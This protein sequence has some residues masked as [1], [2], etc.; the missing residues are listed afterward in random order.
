MIRYSDDAT[1]SSLFTAD[2]IPTIRDRYGLTNNTSN[3]TDR[4]G[5]W[6]AARIT[7]ADMT[8][9]LYRASEDKP[10]GTWLLEV[11]SRTDAFGSD[12]FNQAFGLNG[13]G[14]VHGSK[15]GWGCDSFWTYPSCAI[16]SVGYTDRNFVAVLQLANSYPDP[17]RDTSTH[18]AWLVQISTPKPDPIGSLDSVTNPAPGSLSLSG[19]AADPAAAGYRE[20]VHVYV[21]GPSGTA[22]YPGM[23][24]GDRRSDVANVYAWAGA[25]SGFSRTVKTQG[26]G[27]NNVCVFAINVDPPRTNPLLGCRSIN[28]RNSFGNLDVVSAGGGTFSVQGWALNPNNPGEQVEIHIYDFNSGGDRGYSGF[29]ANT[30]RPDV[31]NAFAGYGGNHGFAMSVPILSGGSHNVCAFSITTGGGDGNTLLGCRTVNVPG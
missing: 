13:L 26:A 4:A 30:S 5:H 22:G 18:S 17:M 12:G 24:T 8:R 20:E 19:W 6:G 10:V 16:H 2:A 11:M 31:G 7:A 14:G 1:A 28:V 9:F 3:A 27:N 23:Y 25:S 21:T 29:R 15:Q